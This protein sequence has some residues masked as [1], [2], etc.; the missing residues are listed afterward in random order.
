MSFFNGF[1]SNLNE[2]L[3]LAVEIIFTFLLLGIPWTHWNRRWYF[4]HIPLSVTVLLTLFWVL[5]CS[6][7]CVGGQVNGQVEAWMNGGM[8][9]LCA[10]IFPRFKKIQNWSF[11]VCIRLYMSVACEGSPRWRSC[12]LWTTL[13]PPPLPLWHCCLPNWSL[14]R[15]ECI[16]SSRAIPSTKN[17]LF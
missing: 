17:N 1:R 10:R 4:S 11:F 13:P 3:F 8:H 12:C 7:L 5:L 6:M 16:P 9:R 15:S 2:S 14:P